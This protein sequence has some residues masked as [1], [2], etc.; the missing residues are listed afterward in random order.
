MFFVGPCRVRLAW[1]DLRG[2]W[3]RGQG[4][5]QYGQTGG[6][7]TRLQERREPRP[8]NLLASYA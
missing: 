3:F 8:R 5:R 7:E 1:G 4:N 6:N 2:V